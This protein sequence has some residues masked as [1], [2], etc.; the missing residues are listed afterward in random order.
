[1]ANLPHEKKIEEYENNVRRFKEQNKDNPLFASEISKLESKLDNLKAKIYSELN[2]TERLAICRHP[3]RPHT[4]HYIENICDEFTE[5]FGDRNYADDSAVVGG[6][7]RIGGQKFMIIGQEKGH[8]TETRVQRNFGMLNPEGF[9]KALR[10]AKL[11]E[12]FHIP[13]VSLLDSPGAFP[14]LEAEE[15]GQGWAIAMNL[16]EFA[17]LKTPI[18]IIIIGEGFSGGALGTGVGD[19][20]GMLQHAYYSVISPEGCASILWKD[21]AKKNDATVALKGNAEDLLELGVIDAMIPEP[22]G[23]AHKNPG[24]VFTNVKAFILEQYDELKDLSPEILVE[25]RYVK[26]RKMGVTQSD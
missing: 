22:L 12:K 2:P 15:R 17:R 8:D 24:V 13:I 3:S 20:V 5:L 1:M 11:A 18:L 10:L 7:A 25:N 16:R 14:G 21:A 23:G 6:I 4:I 26:Y 19:V 9:R